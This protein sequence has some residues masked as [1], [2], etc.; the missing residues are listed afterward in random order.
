MREPALAG[1]DQRKS[2]ITLSIKHQTSSP[3]PSSLSPDFSETDSLITKRRRE[4]SEAGDEEVTGG[5]CV[6]MS[7]VCV[8]VCVGE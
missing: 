8:C 3:L 5:L 6:H 7:P 1:A 4:G 2:G